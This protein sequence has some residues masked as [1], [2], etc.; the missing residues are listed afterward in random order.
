MSAD[1]GELAGPV[2]HRVGGTTGNA[3]IHGCP[4]QP[5][6]NSGPSTAPSPIPAPAGS[7]SITGPEDT[8][9]ASVYLPGTSPMD[10]SPLG[11]WREGQRRSQSDHHHRGNSLG[12]DSEPA[13]LAGDNFDV[14]SEQVF[15]PEAR[16]LGHERPHILEYRSRA[17]FEQGYNEAHVELQLALDYDA[18]CDYQ[19]EQATAAIALLL[20]FGANVRGLTERLRGDAY[21]CPWP[22]K[23]CPRCG[24]GAHS[25]IHDSRLLE[26]YV[27]VAL[28]PIDQLSLDTIDRYG[29][30]V[31]FTA[32]GPRHYYSCT[33]NNRL[34]IGFGKTHEHAQKRLVLDV[35][36]YV[37]DVVTSYNAAERF[38]KAMEIYNF[39]RAR[40]T[41][42][43]PIKA[44]MVQKI[45]EQAYAPVHT[46]RHTG[47][48]PH[49]PVHHVSLSWAGLCVQEY[50]E[51]G[52]RISVVEE[53][54]YGSLYLAMSRLRLSGGRSP[55][56]LF[57]RHLRVRRRPMRLRGSRNEDCP[58]CQEAVAPEHVVLECGGR[59]RIC[60]A[61]SDSCYAQWMQNG[62]SGAAVEGG[63]LYERRRCPLCREE[64][65]GHRRRV[66]GGADH[67]PL[68]DGPSGR[69]EAFLR[70]VYQ[71]DEQLLIHSRD[72]RNNFYGNIRGLPCALAA[73]IATLDY[74]RDHHR[75]F[76]IFVDHAVMAQAGRDLE[77]AADE[78]AQAAR[79]YWA[80][81]ALHHDAALTEVAR[82][83]VDL[84][85]NFR[86][87][88]VALQ[89][90]RL[91]PVVFLPAWDPA[92]AIDLILEPPNRGENVGHYIAFNRVQAAA[93]F[94]E[95]RIVVAAEWEA[96]QQM[97]EVELQELNA[98]ED[99]RQPRYEGVV[100][101]VLSMGGVEVSSALPVPISEVSAHL[102]DG[103]RRE[104]PPARPAPA[105]RYPVPEYPLAAFGWERVVF[106]STVSSPALPC[107]WVKLATKDDTRTSHRLDD[108]DRC[109]CHMSPFQLVPCKHIRRADIVLLGPGYQQLTNNSLI[110]Y[111]IFALKRHYYVTL[112][113][114]RLDLMTLPGAHGN[115]A[116]WVDRCGNQLMQPAV[117]NP[118]GNVVGVSFCGQ[119]IPLNNPVRAENG[120]NLAVLVEP[121]APHHYLIAR[122]TAIISDA[123]DP[124]NIFQ[125]LKGVAVGFAFKAMTALGDPALAALEGIF[126]ALNHA[127]LHYG[128]PHLTTD[129]FTSP[130]A[131]LVGKGVAVLSALHIPVFGQV[132]L[133]VM[134]ALSIKV[135]MYRL[136]RDK[137]NVSGPWADL[138][139][140]GIVGLEALPVAIVRWMLNTVDDPV[141]RYGEETMEGPCLPVMADEEEVMTNARNAVEAYRLTRALTEV[142][143]FQ[144]A[145]T[146]L[147]NFNRAGHL[148]EPRQFD[149]AVAIES[150]NCHRRARLT[151]AGPIENA[152]PPRGHCYNYPFCMESPSKRSKK[153]SNF[154]LCQKC[155]RTHCNRP[156]Q[157]PTFERGEAV[158]DGVRITGRVPLLAVRSRYYGCPENAEF[159]IPPGCKLTTNVSPD[160]IK[161]PEFCKVRK[162]GV[163]VGYVHPGWTPSHQHQ[164]ISAV[165]QGLLERTYQYGPPFNAQA[166]R[167]YTASVDKIAEKT[168]DASVW[169]MPDEAWLETQE[170]EPE[171]RLAMARLRQGYGLV[172]EDMEIG[173]FSK[174][175][176]LNATKAGLGPF[177]MS[178]SR[179]GYKKRGI[180]T[181]TDVAHCSV[182]PWARPMQQHIAD[183]F[184]IDS[185]YFYAGKADPATLNACLD[186]FV[187]K[188]DTHH[189]LM[190]DI[191]RCETN[192]HVG[193]VEARMSYYNR[194]WAVQDENREKV[195]RGWKRARFRAKSGIG[196]ASGRLP[197]NMTLS[198]EDMTSADNSFDVAVASRIGVYCVLH[199]TRPSDLPLSDVGLIEQFWESGMVY[200]AGNGDDTTIAI[201][202]EFL[203]QVVE[204]E[205]FFR[206]YSECM[207]QM[208]FMVTGKWSRAV[209]DIVFLGMR[210]YHCSDGKYRFGRLIGRSSVKNHFARD[211][212]G[213]PYSWLHEVAKA[214]ALTMP[215]VPLLFHKAQRICEVLPPVIGGSRPLRFRDLKKLKKEASWL[216]VDGRGVTYTEQTW[217]DLAECYSLSVDALK[218]EVAKIREARWFPYALSGEV[219]ERI[220]SVDTEY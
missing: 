105:H 205:E 61:G 63:V 96:Y 190:A 16:W 187:Q 35:H 182:G 122:L 93:H 62:Y 201:P 206:R 100:P 31:Q 198:G 59:H 106:V 155:L 115:R 167:L 87:V 188:I 52:E 180:Y 136:F 38:P 181:P 131:W 101:G 216:N 175:E 157:E 127:L 172:P 4:S 186:R 166:V 141:L 203:G 137:L 40:A 80:E 211:L 26:S 128:L 189:I 149:V 15:A 124:S 6:V 95:P 57:G 44:L 72:H 196:R 23:G 185:G 156:G 162:M 171:L 89:G 217:R 119:N 214:E 123:C 74:V 27:A 92:T 54:A 75:G 183:L 153:R 14:H 20:G 37:T 91:A 107:H 43:Q 199:N 164:G 9:N 49:R 50:G 71:A 67:P 116:Y 17:F 19:I 66:G 39:V 112:H 102:T 84:N 45:T 145:A 192:K 109:H 99:R 140:I 118:A 97:L 110:G 218:A 18:M 114:G 121:V 146:G 58:I 47:G 126:N 82:M 174:S 194:K 173:I 213:C 202:R 56:M 160:R 8:N 143:T 191:A 195:I 200:G 1:L 55:D 204:Q 7:P 147:I 139:F 138:G 209:W 207:K 60:N 32:N 176:W 197:P 36:E 120:G 170:R 83:I 212:Q 108:P 29:F 48:P 117:C 148:L 168:P 68:P 94:R 77:R 12:L 169:N 177:G 134:I 3:V 113:R 178:H 184:H 165:V 215:H 130:L 41:E 81:H 22:G 154:N 42:G 132:F 51:E 163:G 152:P 34:F 5:P 133:L 76:G 73:I 142:S 144:A 98:I 85:L 103:D 33:T 161:D 150:E 10:P 79:A 129:F 64:V 104:V 210:P 208:G 78:R 24:R 53:R 159:F 125:G 90:G 25:P 151:G 11:P 30:D 65:G 179:H 21:L 220:F 219:W 46:E 158:K 88:G 70:T 111:L 135:V 2:L 193:V 69:T 28:T 13:F 86:L